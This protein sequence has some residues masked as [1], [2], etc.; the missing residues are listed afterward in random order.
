MDRRRGYRVCWW[1]RQKPT[2][3]SYNACIEPRI[4]SSAELPKLNDRRLI[5]IGVYV[6]CICSS[7]GERERVYGE[8]KKNQRKIDISKE[9]RFGNSMRSTK[10]PN[11]FFSALRKAL[12]EFSISK[13]IPRTFHSRRW[14]ETWGG[15]GKLID[16]RLPFSNGIKDLRRQTNRFYNLYSLIEAFTAAV[17]SLLPTQPR[18]NGSSA[19]PKRVYASPVIKFRGEFIYRSAAFKSA[20][21]CF[22]DVFSLSVLAGYISPRAEPRSTLEGRRTITRPSLIFRDSKREP[23]GFH[24][25]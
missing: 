12:I 24:R 17:P 13:N 18:T 19:I 5:I 4:N 10:F 15:S 22:A 2:R 14:E 6:S 23:S 25:I 9:I 16:A 21:R 11:L 7:L 20:D 8:S 1:I 3:F